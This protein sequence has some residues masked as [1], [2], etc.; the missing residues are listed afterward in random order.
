MDIVPATYWE[1]L[2]RYLRRRR[3]YKRLSGAASSKKRLKTTRLG[4]KTRGIWKLRLAPRLKIN[5]S[6]IKLLVKFHDAY[7]DLMTHLVVNSN[8]VLFGEKRRIPQGR[9]VPNVV[10][11]STN[12]KN[13]DSKLV[14]EIYKKLVSSKELAVLLM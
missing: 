7:V 12:D 6:P 10:C 2:K 4:G 11:A 1:T 13:G 14:M 8:V 3:R 5:V 9:P